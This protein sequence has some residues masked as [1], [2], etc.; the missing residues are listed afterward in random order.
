ML[1]VEA[2]LK[3]DIKLVISGRIVLTSSEPFKTFLNSSLLSDSTAL[4]GTP[5]K[6]N[7]GA[8]LS[9]SNPDKTS[10][11]LAFLLSKKTIVKIIG[12]KLIFN[13]YSHYILIEHTIM[14]KE[15]F[16]RDFNSYNQNENE[17]VNQLND[18]KAFAKKY[19]GASEDEIISQILL[20]AQ[21]GRRNGTLSDSDIDRFKNMLYPMLNARQREK[22]EKVV[23]K[24]KNN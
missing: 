21:K 23:K 15:I 8:M 16:M 24:I 7:K 18:L 20:E 5:N 2:V 9:T 10:L 19:E 6:D 12:K 11:K 14:L 1:A 17:S 3:L 4:S 13:L 22:L